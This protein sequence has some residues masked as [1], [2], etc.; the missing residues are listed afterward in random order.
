MK[1]HRNF[2]PPVAPTSRSRTRHLWEIAALRDLAVILLV[3]SALLAVYFLWDIF[4]PAFLGLLMAHFCNPAITYLEQRWR[5]P[6]TLTVSL[7]LFIGF[8]LLAVLLIWLGPLLYEQVSQL[9]GN[10]PKYAKAIA[11][12]FEIEPGMLKEQLDT[13]LTR[14]QLDPRQLIAQIFRGTDRA[15][16]WVTALID[17]VSNLTLALVLIPVYFFVFAWYFNHGLAQ[18]EVYLPARHKGQILQVLG[19]MDR[20]VSEFFRGQLVIA[21]ADGALFSI[22]WY[23]AGVPYWFALGMFT[24][25]LNIVPYLSVVGWP[26]A[27]LLKYV[28]MLGDGDGGLLAAALWPTVVYVAVQL[29]D[30]WV[31]APWIQSGQTNLSVVTI[32]IV[33]LVGA[34]LAGMWGMFFAIPVAACSKIVLVT[35]LLPRLERWAAEH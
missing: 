21:M 35:V 3:V 7:I 12:R 6:R 4:L 32:I 24:G 27:V 19:Q 15:F 22:G 33:V 20:A 1:L 11:A 30:G 31:L 34:A 14:A 17:V 5:W 2:S 8:A 10:L 29:F 9:I 26:L 18:L 28:S 25:L 16:G 13:A 23:W